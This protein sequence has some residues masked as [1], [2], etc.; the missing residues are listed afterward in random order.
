MPS[1]TLRID[2]QPHTIEAP[3][4]MPLLRVLRHPVGATGSGSGRGRSRLG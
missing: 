2:G 4:A 1:Y 3:E